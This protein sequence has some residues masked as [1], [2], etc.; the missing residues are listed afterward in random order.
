MTRA[1]NF[2]LAAN[3]CVVEGGLV[4]DEG[5]TPYCTLKKKLDS[6]TEERKYSVLLTKQSADRLRADANRCEF[7][8]RNPYRAMDL[9][10]Q[11]DVNQPAL[12]REQFNSLIDGAMEAMR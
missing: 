12:W 6:L 7:I 9:F 10:K 4:G 2:K 8:R 11:I 1:E 5:G 3:Q